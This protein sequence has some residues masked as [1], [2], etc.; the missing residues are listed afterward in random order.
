MKYTETEYPEY[1]AP[2]RNK[3]SYK[4]GNYLEYP[5]V[6]NLTKG[7]FPCVDQRQTIKNEKT[8]NNQLDMVLKQE[9]NNKN[10]TCNQGYKKVYKQPSGNRRPEFFPIP[11]RLFY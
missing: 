2:A 1:Q 8:R 3:S 6:K 11:L 10:T 4:T 7:E 9:D 5:E